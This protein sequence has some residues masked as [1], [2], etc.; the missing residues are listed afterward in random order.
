MTLSIVILQ[1]NKPGDVTQCLKALSKAR[2]PAE[3]EIVVLNNGGND[4]NTKVDPSSYAALKN[5]SFVELP[6]PG[7]YIEGNNQGYERSTGDYVLTLN[8]DITVHE[9]TIERLLA[10][11]QQHPA[12]GI[13][14]PRL[15]YPDGHE[16]DSAR[17]FPHIGELL[18]R[19]LFNPNVHRSARTSFGENEAVESDWITGAAFLMSRACLEK[20]GGHDRRFYLFMSDIA[21]C[22]ET[23]NAGLSVV[24]LRDARA[25]HNEARLSRGGLVAMLKKRTGRWHISDARRYFMHYLFRPFPA[26]CPSQ[27]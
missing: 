8:P 16:Q 26:N 27:R 17:A 11:M 6:S 9:D 1:T 22:R 5:I 20:T 21:L 4:A 19:R 10:Y 23:W 13:A 7:G 25:I 14:A 15:I 18:W 24:Q 12:V 3:T 2:L